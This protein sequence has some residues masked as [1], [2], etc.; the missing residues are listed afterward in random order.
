MLFA[1]PMCLLYFVG[2]FA[3]LALVMRR[4]GRA[5]R[6]APSILLSVLL[7]GAAV[8]YA[9]VIFMY[10]SS[11]N[12]LTSLSRAIGPLVLVLEGDTLPLGSIFTTT[13]PQKTT[14]LLD[15]YCVL[16][17]HDLITMDIVKALQ[18]LHLEKKRLD[19]AIAALEARIEHSEGGTAAK[20]HKGRRGRKSMSAAERLEVSR[21]MTLYWEARR[22]KSAAIPPGSASP[23]KTSRPALPRRP[24]QRRWL[25]FTS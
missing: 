7:I 16:V 17:Y 6:G 1:I 13:R 14:K 22:A 25:Q 4:E 19:A 20:P 15:F 5:S 11:I 24:E 18:E 9:M 10:I 8:A 2:V 12:G 23:A 3:G 21:R